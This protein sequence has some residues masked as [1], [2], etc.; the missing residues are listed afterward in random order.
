LN[1]LKT[2][3]LLELLKVIYTFKRSTSVIALIYFYDSIYRVFKFYVTN[4]VKNRII[5]DFLL[6]VLGNT[7]W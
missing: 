4:T 5:I 2:L 3:N 1:V 6:T 7:Y